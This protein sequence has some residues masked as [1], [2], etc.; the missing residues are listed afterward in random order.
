MFSWGNQ[1][2]RNQTIIYT[3]HGS[4]KT[5]GIFSKMIGLTYENHEA[6]TMALF[7]QLEKRMMEKKTTIEKTPKMKQKQ[8]D[9]CARELK[10]LECLVNYEGRQKK[11]FDEE[12]ITQI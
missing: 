10:C 5:S 7:E 1:E 8:T 6:Q 9:G 11:S 2:S 4:C 3:L 12:I